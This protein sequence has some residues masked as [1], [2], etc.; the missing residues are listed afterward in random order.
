MTDDQPD[1]SNA[2]AHPR[3]KWVRSALNVAG[4]AI[5]F[6]GGFIAAASNVW[7]EAE[8]ERALEALRAWIRMLEDE[9]KEKQRTI[10]EIMARLDMHEER[11]AER[12]RSSEYQSLV[13][14]AF[15]NWAGTESRKKQDYIRNILTNAAS[16]SI[17][18]DDVVRLFVK[19]LHDYSELHFA[20]IGELYKNPGSTRGEI[21]NNLGKGQVREDSADADLF[22]LLIRDLSTGGIIRQHRETDYAGNFIPKKVIPSRS[23]PR[24]AQRTMKSAFDDGESYELTSLGQQFVHYAMNEVT[25]RIEYRGADGLAE[26]GSHSRSQPA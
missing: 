11:I 25:V 7:G 16:A 1:N 5:P 14:Q 12:V 22:R 13:K 24:G 3:N 17:V 18:S 2:E 23:G 19:W 10:L 4:G 6:A 9:L 21:W 8:Q 20:V 26:E 15:R